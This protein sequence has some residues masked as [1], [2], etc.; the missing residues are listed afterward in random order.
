MNQLPLHRQVAIASCLVE[1][2]SVRSTARITNTSKNTVLKLLRRLGKACLEYQEEHIR[3][4]KCTRMQCDEIWAYVFAKDSTK[5]NNEDAGSIWTWVALCPDCKLAPCWYVGERGIH[6]AEVFMRD[7]ASRI[8]GRVQIS[9]DA[10]GPYAGA[11]EAAFG[12]R[13][14]YGRLNKE[15]LGRKSKE[16]VVKK[17]KVLG[18]PNEKDISTSYCERHNLNMRMNIRRFTRK[19]N[20]FSKKVENHKFAISL[21]FMH[22][23]FVRIHGTLKVT[24]AMEAGVTNK[25]WSLADI[26][27]LIR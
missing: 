4:L 25:I 14:D 27:N 2:A 3:D 15:K 13:A 9:T 6:A 5:S 7:L 11:V 23:N 10:H 24:P 21:H 19:T 20:A 16:K 12:A 22:Y 26:V 17:E 18:K 1:G 8:P